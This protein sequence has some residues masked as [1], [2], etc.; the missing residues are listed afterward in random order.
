MTRPEQPLALTDISL[1]TEVKLLEG[2]SAFRH[3]TELRDLYEKLVRNAVDREMSADE[4]AGLS[5]IIHDY[6]RL[7]EP[8]DFFLAYYER[9]SQNLN[10][11]DLSRKYEE[12]LATR[13]I[14]PAAVKKKIRERLEQAGELRDVLAT[15]IGD[16]RRNIAGYSQSLETELVDIENGVWPTR[17]TDEPSDDS[18]FE[19]GI[20]LFGIGLGAA[21]VALTAPVTVPIAV[22]LTLTTIGGLSMGFGLSSVADSLGFYDLQ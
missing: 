11:E 6:R 22:V 9:L 21:A 18:K 4:R 19:G 20:A 2:L 7:A 1:E 16:V 13:T 3:L 12:I 14:A 15:S 5:K 10:S 17:L 8:A